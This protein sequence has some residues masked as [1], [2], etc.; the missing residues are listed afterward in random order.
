MR[1]QLQSL[2]IDV[3]GYNIAAIRQQDPATSDLPKLLCLHGWL[4]NA[5]SFLP[6]LPYLPGFDLV[7][8]DLPGHGHSDTLPQGYH[9][10]E[11]CYQ[12]TRF[13]ESLGWSDCHVVG[14]SLGACIAPMLAVANPSLVTTM[15]MIEASGSLS[16]EADALPARMSRALSERLDPTRF[17]SRVFKSKQEA[18]TSRLKAATM[19]ELSARLIIDRQ[20]RE[21]A[22]GY[23]WRFDPRWRMASAQ[24]QTEAQVRAVLSAV[25]C[26]TLTIIAEDGFLTTRECSEDRLNCLQNRQTTTLPGNHHLHMDTPEP[27]ATAINRFLEVTPALGG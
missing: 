20:L 14:H 24:Y 26:K 17:T 2:T 5:N 15:T 23:R 19:H 27:V 6:M 9:P 11:L 3:D 18:T 1:P 7:A 8:I 21:D 10:H 22:D 25:S 13:V 12:L 16:E 4:D